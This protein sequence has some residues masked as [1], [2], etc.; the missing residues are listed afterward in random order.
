MRRQ[1]PLVLCLFLVSLPAWRCS[2]TSLEDLK[3]L[4][5]ICY[6]PSYLPK[7]FKLKSCD[8]TYDEIPEYKR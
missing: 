1:L 5:I 4:E 2:A 6:V 8:I 7:G 3:K